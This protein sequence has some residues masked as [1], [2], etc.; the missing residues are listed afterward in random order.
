MHYVQGASG[1][2]YMAGIIR[3]FG[4]IHQYGSVFEDFFQ[5]RQESLRMLT[6]FLYF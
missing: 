3:S 2:V 5:T 1:L 4:H 6:A